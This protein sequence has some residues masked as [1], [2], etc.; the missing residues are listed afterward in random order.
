MYAEDNARWGSRLELE[1][2]F[3]KKKKGNLEIERDEKI[4]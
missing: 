2:K 4:L 1:V 3:A